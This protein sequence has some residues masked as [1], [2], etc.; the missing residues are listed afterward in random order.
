MLSKIAVLF[1]IFPL[2]QLEAERINS[3]Y[4]SIS[5]LHLKQSFSNLSYFDPNGAWGIEG[6]QGKALIETRR[7]EGG[8]DINALLNL[9]SG[10]TLWDRWFFDWQKTPLYLK[11]GGA[12]RFIKRN[13]INNVVTF[14][15]IVLKLAHNLNLRL[16]GAVLA[17]QALNIKRITLE[18]KDI[19]PIFDLL[20]RQPFEETYPFL[21]DLKAKGSLEATARGI[22]FASQKRSEYQR[23]SGN[24]YLQPRA[25]IFCKFKGDIELPYASFKDIHLALPIFFQTPGQARGELKIRHIS[26]KGMR[27]PSL[28]LSLFSFKNGFSLFQPTQL[29]LNQGSLTIHSF[30]IFWPFLIQG[31]LS[32]KNVFLSWPYFRG[33]LSSPKLDFKL[34]LSLLRVKGK[35]HLKAYGGK[36][37]IENI[38]IKSPFSP[39]AKIMADISFRD[40]DLEKFSQQF[41]LGRIQGIVKGQIKNL[42]IAYG[43][44]ESF[45]MTIESVK[46]RG[47]RQS[48]SLKAVNNIAILAQG[49][50]I[51]L[52]GLLPKEF[53]YQKIGI[54]CTLKNDIFII[55]GLIKRDGVEYLVKRRLFGINII[56]RSPGQRVP[57]KEMLKRFKQIL[58]EVKK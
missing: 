25:K 13:K 24:I 29:K 10:Q 23:Q 46:K 15:K 8:I 14:K 38:I 12:L 9:R 16:T 28:N 55:H 5:S 31:N 27:I 11:A 56:N 58:K 34:D 42:V 1:L 53:S 50:P 20:L 3:F 39:S 40:I 19:A 48:I 7:T 41:P 51:S 26:L 33:L 52:G 49:H 36:I 6:L 17:P 22:Y 32:I 47:I 57:F 4:N 2:L 54:R 44:P 21:A 45:D 37:S 35:L 43:Q 30:K 18:V